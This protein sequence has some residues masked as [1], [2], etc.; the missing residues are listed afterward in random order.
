MRPLLVTEHADLDTMLAV[1]CFKLANETYVSR[2]PG[3]Q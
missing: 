2:L 3:D 1:D